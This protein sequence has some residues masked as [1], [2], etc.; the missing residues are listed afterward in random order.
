MF[1]LLLQIKWKYSWR[2]NLWTLFS[3]PHNYWLNLALSSVWGLKLFNFS[4]FIIAWNK[5]KIFQKPDLWIFFRCFAALWCLCK[6]FW[7][8]FFVNLDFGMVA[9][10]FP[11]HSTYLMNEHVTLV[12]CEWIG[13]AIW[14]PLLGLLAWYPL[15]HV[16]LL[17]LIWG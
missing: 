11:L 16:K 5:K 8:N 6:Y 1:L 17:Q 4:I 7:K 14:H 2:L 12:A 15:I 3:Y 13:H 9:F 10:I